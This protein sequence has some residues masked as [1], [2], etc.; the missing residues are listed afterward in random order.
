MTKHKA[1]K[2]AI[3]DWL[4]EDSSHAE[5][6]EKAIEKMMEAKEKRKSE[7]EQEQSRRKADALQKRASAMAG[8]N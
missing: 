3:Q 2:K 7:F 6:F 1:P 4:K 5:V 8:G